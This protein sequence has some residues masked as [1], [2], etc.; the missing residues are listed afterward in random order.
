MVP[1]DYQPITRVVFGNGTLDRLGE[2]VREIGG[3]RALVVTDPGIRAAG[4]VE[5]SVRSLEAAGIGTVVFDRVEENPTTRHVADCVSLARNQQIDLLIGLGGGSAMDTAKGANFLLS[6]GGAMADYWGIGKATKPMLPMVAVPTTAGTGSEA[7]SFA[8]IADE[9]THQK[10]ACGDKKATCKAAI[11]DPQITVSQPARVTAV[12]GIDA[13][14]HALETY[15]TTRRNPI[16]LMYAR[17]AWDLLQTGFPRVLAVPQ[18]LEA[19]GQMLL[20]AHL[21][22]AAI[23]NSMLGATHSAANP[24]TAHYGVTHGAA[25]GV[26]LP[27]V[28]RFNGNVCDSQYADLLSSCNNGSAANQLA[29]QITA[30][31][32]QAGLPSA[33][34][35]YGV[36]EKLLPTLAEEAASQW[37]ARFNPRPLTALDFEQL[38][39]V[40]Y[41]G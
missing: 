32:R 41:N 36:Q 24:L 9:A 19:R 33:L 1:F 14:A 39:R 2:I 6:N 37:T 23:E 13:M 18:D 15:V 17:H 35:E 27:H 10:M 8:L 29:E 28:I 22:G 31:L 25:I 20:G 5:R 26:M 38:Y 3:Q 21:A 40:A 30:W 11:L 7:Q 34:K 4:H 16:S 12:C